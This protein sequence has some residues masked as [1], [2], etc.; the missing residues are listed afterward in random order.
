MS[1][2]RIQLIQVFIGSPGGLEIERTMFR[3]VVDE[4]NRDHS[5]H[6]GCM[7][8]PVGWE[9]TLPGRG[10]PQALINQEL[11]RCE[12]FIGVM[13]DHWG[14]STA[15]DNPRFTSGFE[16]EFERAKQHV[17]SGKMHDMTVYFKAIPPERL[18]DPG[19][20][21]QRVLEFKEECF[22]KRDALYKEYS[23]EDDFE[24][25]IR[26]KLNSIGWAEF[27][28]RQSG[29]TRETKVEAPQAP[30]KARP[31]T[32]SGK[33]H[34]FSEPTRLFLENIARRQAGWEETSAVE[35]ARMRLVAST[36]YRSGNDETVLG[37]HDA[38]LLF[39]YRENV[40]LGSEEIGGL[41]DSG[42]A[43]FGSQN[44][45]LWHWIAHHLEGEKNLE[46]LAITA[47]IAD[48]TKQAHAVRLI[49]LLGIEPSEIGAVVSRER[50]IRR[51]L[52][53]DAKRGVF[54]EALTYL[55]RHGKQGDI[56][57]LE[58]LYHN[59]TSQHQAKLGDLIL[60]L[61]ARS[62]ATHALSR[63]LELAVDEVEEKT[64]DELFENSAS[65]A[66]EILI[67]CAQSAAGI[68]RQRSAAILC[69]R[70]ALH[71]EL[72][73]TLL[74]D[75]DY[76]VRYY[77]ALA[78]HSAGHPLEDSLAKKA[79]AIT[80]K[81]EGLGSLFAQTEINNE[82]LD[83]YKLAVLSGKNFQ[84][85]KKD[86]DEGGILDEDA[87]FVLF[88]EYPTK[89][90]QELREQ[91]KDGFERY[92]DTRLNDLQGVLGSENDAFNKTKKHIPFL[93]KR[94]T[95]AAIEALC[96]IKQKHDLELVRHVLDTYEV[97]LSE[98]AIE[99]LGKFGDWS[100][101]PRIKAMTEYRPTTLNLLAIG[102]PKALP[103]KAAA[104]LSIGKDRIA[105]LLAEDMELM[106]RRELLKQ[107]K[108]K[109]VASMS[110][111]ILLQ[112]LGHDDDECRVIIALK[113]AQ[114]LSKT[115]LTSLLKIYSDHDGYRYYN[116]IHWLDL[117]ASMPRDTGR[118]IA[119][120]ELDR[121]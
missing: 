67:E 6:W 34:L 20:S 13:F 62:G 91:L 21:L 106:L 121:H 16:E 64:A 2:S 54:T 35:A 23:D 72:A 101:L 110:D 86:Y 96:G 31:E 39:R 75:P 51:W 50:T 105:D 49:S 8:D 15:K 82:H 116:S 53:E 84:E 33:N 24:T 102:F 81:N 73:G 48:E 61:E 5:R 25:L 37:A 68:I 77:A 42:I 60:K 100:D 36:L 99:F 107:L 111:E 47:S 115:R 9:E 76:T 30:V 7:L 52:D 10:R 69:D 119:I 29:L 28:K 43:G 118:T 55:E 97:D 87:A 22:S 44:I 120:Q 14:S 98:S 38:N 12:Y 93:R 19:T 40:E 85:L 63:A 4:L 58:E 117:G 70:G 66:T 104:M 45:P 17:N 32:E 11:D 27:E 74:S 65:L 46:N 89:I 56:P 79:L 94:L 71:M 59:S 41:I 92:F 26:A 108:K 78:L 83:R 18:R 114:F 113:C 80:K 95:T 3:D 57:L 112:V 1:S 103:P 88:R 90:K 109:D